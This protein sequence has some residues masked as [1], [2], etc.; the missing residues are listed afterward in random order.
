M[1]HLTLFPF[2]NH[3]TNLNY[4]KPATQIKHLRGK[5][6]IK[7]S[8]VLE[9]KLHTFLSTPRKA[10]YHSSTA[11]LQG[12]QRK[13]ADLQHESTLSSKWP[14]PF[15]MFFLSTD[16]TSA[17]SMSVWSGISAKDIKLCL[18]NNLLISFHNYS[19][20]NIN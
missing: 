2:L 3:L 19:R 14:T 12:S 13:R 1:K 8:R 15:V 9:S 18:L 20:Y 4:W 16:L 11:E 5:K 6:M 17:S 7:A 10:L